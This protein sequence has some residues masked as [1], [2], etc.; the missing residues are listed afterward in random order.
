MDGFFYLIKYVLLQ[1]FG[2]FIALL[3]GAVFTYIVLRKLHSRKTAILL[4]VLFFGIFLFLYAPRAFPN[5]LQYPFGLTTYGPADSPALPLKNVYTFF[6]KLDQFERIPDIARDPN[7]IPPPITRTENETVEITMTAKEV[8]AEMAPGVV[9]NYWTYD[10]RVPGP[11]VRILE[12]DTVHFTLKNDPTSIHRHNIDLHAVTGPG[13]GAVATNVAPGESKTFTFK[14]LNPGLYVYHCA[15][16]NVGN[17][18]AHGMYGLILVQPKN[19]ADLPAVDK[20]FYVM[21]GEFYPKGTIG[22]KGLQVMDAQKFLDGKPEY[23]VFNG[24]IGGAVGKMEAKTGETVRVY[25]GNGGVNLI[26]SFHAI[27]EIFDRVFPEGAIGSAPHQNVQTTLVPAGGAT[28]VDFALQVPG[29]FIFVDHALAR[30]DRGAYGNLKVTGD[31]DLS[32]F[33]GE[34]SSGGGH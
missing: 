1:G 21:Q 16:P 25:V 33:D 15:H 31:P 29:T 19:I 4:F 8:I 24:K 22:T 10:G 9:M 32:V 3:A 13:G 23:I 28:I 11:F 17:H 7:D 14:A 30:L 18:M 34:I 26:S 6:S 5:Q 27:G 2:L 20:E 12:G